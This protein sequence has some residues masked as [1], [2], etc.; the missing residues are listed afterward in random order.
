MAGLAKRF[1]RRSSGCRK[2]GLKACISLE[3]RGEV[4]ARTALPLR[5]YVVVT[6]ASVSKCRAECS[7]VHGS[8]LRRSVCFDAPQP[9]FSRVLASIVTAPDQSGLPH[10]TGRCVEFSESYT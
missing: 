9:Q 8:M 1:D 5:L 2:A 3:M 10:P 6:K 4:V 7:C